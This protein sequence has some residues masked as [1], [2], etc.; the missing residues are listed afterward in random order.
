MSFWMVGV[1][2][3]ALTFQTGRGIGGR[4]FITNGE[5]HKNRRERHKK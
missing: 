2:N 1:A 4:C 3:V 5:K